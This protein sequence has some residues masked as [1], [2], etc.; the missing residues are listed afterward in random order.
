[1]GCTRPGDAEAELL[2]AVAHSP[3]GPHLPTQHCIRTV[4]PAL[5][6][7]PWTLDPGPWTLDLGPWTL[8]PGPWTLNP[9]P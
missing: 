3:E 1:M 4:H 8:D 9:E 5:D 6:P 7:G 2:G